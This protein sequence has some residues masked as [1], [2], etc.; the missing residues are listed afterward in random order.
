M[1][2]IFKRIPT[3]K[4]N[5]QDI[6]LVHYYGNNSVLYDLLMD[7]RPSYG[8]V[9]NKV[10]KGLEHKNLLSQNRKWFDE[11]YIFIH[12]IRIEENV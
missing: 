2:K 11:N 8:K 3:E 1:C 4:N 5:L 12:T 10:K 6:A 7:D 9:V